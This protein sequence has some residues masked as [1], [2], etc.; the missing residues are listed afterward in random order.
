MVTPIRN[1]ADI[2]ALE[3]VPLDER[4]NLWTVYDVLKA[5]AA[6]DPERIALHYLP[7]ARPDEEPLSIS[8]RQF[9]GEMHKSANLFHSLGIGPTDVVAILLPNLP[10]NYMALFGAIAAGVA[11]PVNWM[12]EASQ[13]AALLKMA[14]AKVLVALGPS[15]GFDIADKLADIRGAVP[16]LDRV[17]YV[18]L[19]GP[20]SDRADDFDRLK[21]SQPGDRLISGRTI[22]PDEDAML[23]HTG[24]T[25]GLP[26]IARIRHRAIAYKCWAYSVLLDQQ[27][28]QVLFAGSPLFHV[29]GIIHN[30]ISSLARGINH[31]VIGPL[32][33]R[34]KEVVHNYWKLVER[35]RITDLFGVPTTLAALANVPVG[36]ADISSLRPYA[37]T[38]SAG[39]PIQ[40]SNYFRD[41][42]GVRLLSGYGMTEN[43][44]TATLPPRDGDPRFASSGIRLPYTKVRAVIIDPE[45]QIVRDCA[46]DE[47]GEIVLKG[48]G[49]IP[50][51]LDAAS[52]ETLFVGDGW[53]R[54]GDL[55]RFDADGYIWVT[56]RAKD[57]IIRGG[58][59]IDPLLIEETLMKHSSVALAAAVGKPDAYAGELPVAF[60]QLKPG[61]RAEP[62]E[63]KKFAREHIAERAAAPVEVTILDA[64][65]LTGVGKIFRPDLRA[66]A[67][68]RV[69]SEIV[70]A[71]AGSKSIYELAIVSDQ[72]RG[73]VARIVLA[74]SAPADHAEI[75]VKLRAM[76]DRF[77]FG[78]DLVWRLPADTAS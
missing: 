19:N 25:T 18:N 38:G 33:F 70:G 2:E 20:S 6:I 61:Q 3:R 29:G 13:I 36:D 49:V 8:Y 44:A 48:P 76:L 12:L 64:I 55:G 35:Y 41:V 47:I 1:L 69:V 52:N 4:T 77:T 37:M 15:P 32:G 53:V 14:R 67:V 23:I 46:A 42:I 75:E 73:D 78:Y 40:I 16:A 59:N 72:R 21:E 34:N 28:S 58:H 71:I 60:V 68:K 5:G 17:L 7:D 9:I 57:V 56:G 22:R 43:T 62:A 45:G 50:G 65:P 24:G 63:L 66:L 39:L 27:P 54:T 74:P 11:F 51:Y 30:T 10:Q 26:K 31:I